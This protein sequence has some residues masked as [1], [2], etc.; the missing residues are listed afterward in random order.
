VTY[1]ICADTN[2]GT[3]CT[4]RRPGR[5]RSHYLPES[6]YFHDP[7]F[8]ILNAAKAT[9]QCIARKATKYESWPVG[10][11]SLIQRGS[12]P[13][14]QEEIDALIQD[15]FRRLISYTSPWVTQ[16]GLRLYKRSVEILDQHDGLPA[17]LTLSASEFNGL[18]EF[19][20]RADLP[21]DLY[22]PARDQRKGYE[23]IELG[24]EAVWVERIYSPLQWAH[25]NVSIVEAPTYSGLRND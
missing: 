3:K 17:L 8:D 20:R 7:T 21:Y 14:D 1:L 4:S 16:I 10:E 15:I 18:Q 13:V 23:K 25:R 24:G 12:L 22:Y 2:F 5:G 11:T 19:W 9:A 6:L